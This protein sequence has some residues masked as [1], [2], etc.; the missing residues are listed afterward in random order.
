MNDPAFWLSIGAAFLL[1]VAPRTSLFVLRGR[2]GD[3]WR[4]RSRIRVAPGKIPL[5]LTWR[6]TRVLAVATVFSAALWVFLTRGYVD[7]DL[8]APLIASSWMFVLLP[9]VLIAANA[10]SDAVR[11][12]RAARL[13]SGRPPPHRR[14]APL[15]RRHHRQL[16]QEQHQGDA[17]RTCLQ[18]HAPTLAAS[19]SINTLMGVTRHIRDELVFG[20]KFMVVEMGAFKTGSIRRLCAADAALGRA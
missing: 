20:H 16:R 2:R 1:T 5:R 12:Q 8:Q 15:H 9:L 7:R 13:R 19:G 11:A 10:C 3:S 6:A 17:R 14:G 18:F 4:S